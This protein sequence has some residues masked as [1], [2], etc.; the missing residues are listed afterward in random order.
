MKSIKK[1]ATGAQRLHAALAETDPAS[2]DL[3]LL[4]PAGFHPALRL[5]PLP[6]GLLLPRRACANGKTA[7]RPA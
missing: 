4:H 1:R 3:I 5:P 7:A 6:P 2:S